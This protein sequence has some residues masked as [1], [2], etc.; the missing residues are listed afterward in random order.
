[1]ISLSFSGSQKLKNISGFLLY[2]IFS[3]L[4]YIF[5][6]SIFEEIFSFFFQRFQSFKEPS[7]RVYSHSLAGGCSENPNPPMMFRIRT[8]R[9]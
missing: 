7:E 1:M 2:M 5:I 6:F 3:F 9:V 8:A 4:F